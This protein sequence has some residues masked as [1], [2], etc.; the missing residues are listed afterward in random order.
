MNRLQFLQ[1]RPAAGDVNASVHMTALPKFLENPRN[2][3]RFLRVLELFV[4]HVTMAQ[5]CF[6]KY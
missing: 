4:S 1:R 5:H 3:L 2:S 6:I